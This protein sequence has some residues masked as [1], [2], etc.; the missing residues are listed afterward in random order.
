MD[1]TYL[2][3]DLDLS[4]KTWDL[5]LT[6]TNWTLDL[7][8]F[9]RLDLDLSW[10][11]CDMIWIC[12]QAPQEFTWTCLEW[13]ESW[14]E[15]WHPYCTWT[16]PKILRNSALMHSGVLTESSKCTSGE[17]FNYKQS[18]T[19]HTFPAAGRVRGNVESKQSGRRGK[20]Q[21]VG[22]RGTTTVHHHKT[23]QVL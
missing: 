14:L 4:W 10:V 7:R 18:N 5:R 8:H 9:D 17:S 15:S 12:S 21:S 16:C 2:T 3:R 20:N 23:C 11:T 19:L 1:L 6:L 22:K 13:L